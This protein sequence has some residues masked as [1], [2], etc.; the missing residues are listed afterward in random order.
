[1]LRLGL[2]GGIGSGKSTVAG[3]LRNLGAVVTDAD[4]VAREVVEPGRPALAAIAAEFGPGVIRAD[5]SLDRAGLATLVFPDP[6]RLR[7]LEAITGPAISA[8]VAALRADVPP[9][10]V[11]V[12]DMPLLVEHGLWVREHL[13]LVVDA[14]VDVRLDRLVAQ[15]GM[16][17]ADAEARIAAQAS[18][19]QRRAAADLWVD[20]GGSRESTQAQVQRMWAERVVPFDAN[21][22]DGIRARRPA[23]LVLREADP[24]WGQAGARVVSRVAAALAGRGVRVDHVGST[25][26]PGLVAKDVVDVQ[27][28]VRRLIDADEPG[29]GEVLR[30]AGYLLVEGRTQDRPHPEGGP[31]SPWSKRLYGGCDPGRVVHVHV[32]EIGSLGW[33]FALAFRDWLRSV[34]RARDEYAG[35]KRSLATQLARTSDYTAAKES[36]FEAAYPRV[37]A[38]VSQVG[39]TP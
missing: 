32:R 6:A 4:R 12:Y 22:R 10:L 19:G 33:R 18:D 5:G 7:A 1:M 36:W 29:F 30:R 13:T 11:D 31:T 15:R 16:P 14:P 23:D 25:S 3:V 2:T 20:N 9:G 17:R 35:Q 24:S 34:P 39:W 27:V 38:W 26:V 37:Q 8:R 28:G 21:L